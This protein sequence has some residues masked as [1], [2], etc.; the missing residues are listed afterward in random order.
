MYYIYYI[1]E[2]VSGNCLPNYCWNLKNVC[3]CIIPMYW[4]P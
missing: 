3:I 4:S 2:L 1:V